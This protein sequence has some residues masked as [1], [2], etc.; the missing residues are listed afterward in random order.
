MNPTS[1][2]IV[3]QH[4]VRALPR[5]ALVLLCLAYLLPGFIGRAPWKKTD[6]EAYGFM[7][8]L[9]RPMAE[10]AVSWLH[11]SLLG[12]SEPNLALLP[13]WLGAWAIQLAPQAWAVQAARL[14]FMLMLLL[15]LVA[16]WQSVYALARLR[17]AQPVAFAFGGEAKPTDYARTLADGGLLALLACLGM[18][19]LSH[20]ITPAL[21]Q[22]CFTALLF[23][24]LATLPR[25][26]LYSGGAIAA[27]M[28]GLTLSGAPVL[29]LLLGTGGV[30]VRV[31]AGPEPDRRALNMLELG[32][33]GLLGLLCVTL[34]GALDLW[35]WRLVP[36]AM[37]DLHLFGRLLLWFTWPAGP[38]ALWALWRWRHQLLRGWRFA[39]IG[40]PLWFAL[41]TVG[42]TWFTG[43]SDRALLSGL[44][45]IAAL[46][47]FALPTLR[48]SVGAFIDWFTLLFFS[49]GALVIWVVWLS[50]ETGWPAQ[51][52][53]NV[54][55]SAPEFT[56]QL[57]WPL[58]LVA[59]VATLAWLGLVRWRTGRHR[60]A[61]WKSLVLP[62]A[63][64]TLCWLL[65]MTLWLP[66]LDHARSYAAL[67]DK[68][69]AIN[70]EA[71][72]VHSIG[73]T[74]AQNAALMVHAGLR[75]RAAARPSADCNWLVTDTDGLDALR[76]QLA[77]WG[78]QE[79]RR[80]RRPTDNNETLV[81]FRPAAP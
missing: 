60:Q 57:I 66:L 81:I 56:H 54:A 5:W 63:G 37:A 44:P 29:A 28:L 17:A 55:R 69:R 73:L 3:A 7:L 10:G 62:A 43:L 51:P 24:G 42:V 33:L 40:L 23:L 30:V 1:P 38:L 75:L 16:T 79:D 26:R 11:P 31:L 72:C 20:E 80:F 49:M 74:N 34:A 46:A 12:Q 22:L 58:L 78:W 71:R 18:A 6:I 27:G 36:H 52:A 25:K 15:T 45:A 47:A 65:L 9:A 35:R 41:V 48:R 21:A 8:Q 76:P 13:T 61:L 77:Q 4:A 64:T 70:P 67:M 14:P 50:M 32:L 19:Q 39:H 2:A 68:L 59:A 53:R